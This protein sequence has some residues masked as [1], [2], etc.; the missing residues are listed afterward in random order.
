M[1]RILVVEDQQEVRELIRMTLELEAY[2]IFEAVDGETALR[3]AL[4][5]VPD[6]VLL[7]V[8]MPGG[9]DGFEVCRRMRLEPTLRRTQI[10]M[11]TARSQ[12][13]D[14]AAGLRAGA[15]GYL[16][17]PFSPRRL[18]ASLARH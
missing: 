16:T 13:A 11:L 1:K 6:L 5:H 4:R 7:D 3:L 15:D 14:R 12:A 17:K 2:E 10:V 18:L 9:I 8:M